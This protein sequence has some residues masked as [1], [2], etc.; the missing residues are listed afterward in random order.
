MKNQFATGKAKR[1]WDWPCWV[2]F[3]VPIL[4]TVLMFYFAFT[5]PGS[6]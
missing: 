6:Y 5:I 1:V 3:I 4:S 2:A